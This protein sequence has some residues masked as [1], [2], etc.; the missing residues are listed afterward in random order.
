[1]CSVCM[2][3]AALGA[4]AI[5]EDSDQAVILCCIA[6]LQTKPRLACLTA[7]QL[8]LKRHTRLD[9]TLDAVQFGMAN[10]YCRLWTTC[11]ANTVPTYASCDSLQ[12]QPTLR[13]AAC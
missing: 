7:K 10:K 13:T 6:H 8:L 3:G 9:E 2:D 11:S 1:M 12:S 5:D 4:G